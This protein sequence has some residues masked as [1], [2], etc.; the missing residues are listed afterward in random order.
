MVWY[1]DLRTV[2]ITEEIKTGLFSSDES[3]VGFEYRVGIQFAL[4]RGPVDQLRRIW[5]GD[6][7]LIDATASPIEHDDTDGFFEP[8]FFGGNDV[9]GNGGMSGTLLF[10][11]GTDTQTPSSYLGNFQVIDGESGPAYRGFCYVGPEAAPFYVGNS[12]NIRP[13]KFELRRIPPGWSGSAAFI[14]VNGADANPVVVIY[15]ILTND[16]WGLGYADSQIDLTKFQFALEQCHGEGNGWSMIQDQQIPVKDVIRLILDQIDG[17]LYQ[18]QETGLWTIDMIRPLADLEDISPPPILA[19]DETNLLNLRNFTRGSWDNTSNQLLLE[20]ND[21]SD[22]YKNTSAGAQDMGNIRIQGVNVRSQVRFPGVKDAALAAKLVWRELVSMSYP[23]AKATVI[24]NRSFWKAKPGQRVTL[25]DEDLGVTTL[26]MRIASLD[27]GR[28]TDGEIQLELV[29]DIFRDVQAAF[30]DVPNSGWEDPAAEVQAFVDQLAFESPRAFNARNFTTPALNRIWATARRVGIETAFDIMGTLAATFEK[31]GGSTGFVLLGELNGSIAQNT[32]TIPWISGGVNFQI[33]ADPDTAADMIA[34]LNLTASDSEIGTQ[35][36][37]LILIGGELMFVR[38]AV[39]DGGNDLDVTEAFRGVLDTK[40]EAHSALDPVWILAAGGNVANILTYDDADDVDIK[41]LPRGLAGTLDIGDATQIDVLIG[42]RARLPYLVSLFVLN[43][44]N[45]NF[46][47]SLDLE[48]GTG[49][50]D[51][52]GT[53][54]NF[55]RRDYRAADETAHLL[56]DASTISGD[57]P[58]ANTHQVLVEVIK[59]YSTVPVSLFLEET[60]TATLTALRNSILRFNAGAVPGEI[61]FRIFTEHIDAGDAL[62]S[63][64]E[65]NV[66]I[67]TITAT[68][69]TGLF[70][71]GATAA[72]PAMSNLFTTATTGTYT[73]R[74]QTALANNLQHRIN[75]GAWTTLITAG[76]TAGTTAALTAGDTIELRHSEIVVG[77]IQLAYLKDNAAGGS[78]DV[79]YWVPYV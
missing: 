67:G 17:V 11:S 74:I 25:T 3:T 72:N 14:L 42:G 28:L 75:G 59:D 8:F 55:R 56:A 73:L 64:S 70:N 27:L 31:I 33:D 44:T 21:R 38:A 61:E 51:T 1:G 32:T 23:L 36:L 78:P 60:D 57:F 15:E 68:S 62:E 7:L 47:A 76:M 49:A 40:Q 9:G 63:L 4:C 39:I 41:L 20:F 30:A 26:S 24:V 48:A 2:A 53:L 16:D 34:A 10:K 52:A 12:A 18:D 79:A 35:L 19:I 58:A 71:M 43:G 77:L 46:P 65:Y 54:F 5:V 22:T 37:N 45:F 69:L 66:Q 29:E 13:W 50:W 6:D